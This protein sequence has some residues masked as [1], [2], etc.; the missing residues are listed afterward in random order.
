MIMDVETYRRMV[1][2][3][4]PPVELYRC[5]LG[6]SMRTTP[7]DTTT[8]QGAII[9][10]GGCGVC[11]Q[12]RGKARS[13]FCS[14]A[15]ANKAALLRQNDRRHGETYECDEDRPWWQGRPVPVAVP[16]GEYWHSA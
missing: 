15:C 12:P 3:G 4:E 5:R 2:L 8:P 7:L 11:G 1:Q 16:A 14:L 13:K 6:H 9:P 10:A